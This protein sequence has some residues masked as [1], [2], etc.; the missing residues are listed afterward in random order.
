MHKDERQC[1]E[2]DKDDFGYLFWRIMK[3]WQR[4]VQQELDEFHTTTS[5]LEILGGIFH[6][7]EQNPSEE[8]TQTQLSALSDIDPMTTSTILRNLEKKGY[9]IRKQSINDTRARSV[10]ITKE[11]VD[12]LEQA[13]YKV[14]KKNDFLLETIDYSKVKNEMDKLLFALEETNNNLKL[15][16]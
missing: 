8:V 2:K 11:G 7:N 9:V 12:L 1:Y 14:K 16:K 15:A 4:T 3:L 5:Q 13:F 6:L 10:F